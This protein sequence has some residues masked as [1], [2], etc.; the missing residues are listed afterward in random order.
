MNIF[1]DSSFYFLVCINF[2]VFVGWTDLIHN[3]FLL[4]SLF[5]VGAYTMKVLRESGKTRE[6]K[7]FSSDLVNFAQHCG[8]VSR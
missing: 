2:L 5:D 1:L 6:L 7:C 4:S 3:Y 8:F